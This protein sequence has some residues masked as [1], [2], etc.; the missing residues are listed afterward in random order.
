MLVIVQNDP[1]VPPGLLMEIVHEKAVP[2]R[3]IRLFSE[4]PFCDLTGVR[5]AVVLGG[6]MSV[7]NTVEFPFLLPLKDWI[8]EIV[9]REIPFLGICL[10]GQLLAEVLGGKVRLHERGEKGCHEISLTELGAAAPLFSGIPKTF[11]SFQWHTDAFDPPLG[12]Q[13]LARSNACPYQAFRF[14]ETAYGIQFHPEVTRAIV[15]AW[16]SDTDDEKEVL[17]GFTENEEACRSAALVF[18][19][20]FLN[21]DRR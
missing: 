4:D 5:G 2:Y 1:V 13:H 12:A 15:S 14:G 20:N 7:H 9:R 10:G 18:L 6:Y 11:V 3:L 8:K 16:V 17:S 21:L 19:N